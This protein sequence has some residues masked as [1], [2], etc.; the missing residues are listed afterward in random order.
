MSQGN[1]RSALPARQRCVSAMSDYDRLPGALRGWLAR[2]IL[3]WSVRSVRRIWRKAQG[4]P[5]T[6]LHLLNQL[7]Q[8]RI[9]Q[10][11]ARIWGP[12][13]PAAS[14]NFH[15]L[16][17][18]HPGDRNQQ[19][20]AQQPHDKLRNNLRRCIDAKCTQQEIRDRRTDDSQHDIKQNARVSLHDHAGNPTGQS[21]NDQR[22]NQSQS[23]RH[24]PFS[25]GHMPS[26]A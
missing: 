14:H 4:N 10:D 3:P 7:E 16:A 2:A 21:T 17:A 19:T 24:I 11:A 22:T 13:H 1:L 12:N 8:Q 20:G 9:S 25:I 5:Q 15:P 18:N 23:H 6:A 26:G